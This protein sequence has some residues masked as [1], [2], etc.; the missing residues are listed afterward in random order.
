[1]VQYTL[2][3]R[4]YDYSIDLVNY[5]CMHLWTSQTIWLIDLS[6]HAEINKHVQGI[7]MYED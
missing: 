7:K 4:T 5:S 2:F 3:P 1:M 6:M